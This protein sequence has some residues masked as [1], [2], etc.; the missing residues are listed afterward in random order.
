MFFIFLLEAFF[1]FNLIRC[2]YDLLL[3]M[4]SM[5]SE[6]S[7][8][9]T[10]RCWW[11]KGQTI[12]QAQRTPSY[13]TE[14]GM[15]IARHCKSRLGKLGLETFELNRRS[16]KKYFYYSPPDTIPQCLY[17]ALTHLHSLAFEYALLLS[18]APWWFLFLY[19]QFR[20]RPYPQEWYKLDASHVYKNRNTLRE[21]QL[22]GVNWLTFCWCNRWPF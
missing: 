15:F 14:T 6:S 2:P 5:I 3:S 17:E 7:S 12:P 13:A 20:P 11:R 18:K 9:F 1:S 8:V 16:K 19:S 22:E 21:Y 10:G 4:K